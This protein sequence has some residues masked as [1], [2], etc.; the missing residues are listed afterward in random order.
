MLHA[1]DPELAHRTWAVVRREFVDTTDREHPA[2][3]LRGWDAMDTGNYQRGEIGA[4]A[5]VMWAA[6]EMGDTELYDLLQASADRRFDLTTERGVRWYRAGSTQA[7]SLLA[8]GR[9]S[10]AGSYRRA[11]EE[12]PGEATRRGPYLEHAAYPDVLVARAATDGEDL[13]LVLRPGTGGGR[14]SLGIERLRPGLRYELKGALEDTVVADQHGRASVT[15]D[16]VDR[17]EIVLAPSA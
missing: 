1:I 6:A 16:L 2:I 13:R 8:V 11:I 15:V 7:N 10:R 4:F 3:S 5:A 9:F 17:Q 14:R 12:G